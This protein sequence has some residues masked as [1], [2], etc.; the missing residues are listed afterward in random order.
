M[1]VVDLSSLWAGPLCTRLLRD[2]GAT[3]I[4]VES[5]VRPDGARLGPPAFFDLLNAGKEELVLDFAAQADELRDLIVR[6]DVVVEGSRPRA[7]AQF[8]I[9]AEDF[10]E[11]HDGPRV[12]VSLT[13]YDRAD[14]RVAFGSGQR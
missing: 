10:L 3:V 11:R 12:W 14:P 13:G 6:A 4:K 8:G 7:L 2:A 5:R 9:S 1:V